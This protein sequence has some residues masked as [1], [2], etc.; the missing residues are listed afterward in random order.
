MLLGKKKKT[1]KFQIGGKGLDIKNCTVLFRFIFLFLYMVNSFR[2]V[3]CLET[4]VIDLGSFC[5]IS[6]LF[7]K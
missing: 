1:F 6:C 5:D 2:H 4:S 3:G 7:F